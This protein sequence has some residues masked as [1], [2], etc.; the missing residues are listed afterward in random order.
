MHN[1]AY[2][3]L[4]GH[5]VLGAHGAYVMSID[6]VDTIVSIVKNGPVNFTALKTRRIASCSHSTHGSELT[7]PSEVDS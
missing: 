7:Q 6:T 3:V 2:I 4:S 5:V 1:G